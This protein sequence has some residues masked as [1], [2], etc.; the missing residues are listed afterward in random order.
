MS[1]GGNGTS[2]EEVR[3]FWEE[4]VE[5]N[6]SVLDVGH[7]LGVILRVQVRQ[8]LQILIRELETE[9]VPE[10]VECAVVGLLLAVGGVPACEGR[11]ESI[12]LDGT[13]G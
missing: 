9:P 5:R 11:S 1:G 12:S 6:S 7:F 8:R 13:R 3:R 4:P 10:V 2:I